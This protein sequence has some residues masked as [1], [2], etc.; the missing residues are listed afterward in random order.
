[1]GYDEHRRA[2]RVLPEGANAY[3][4]AR[5]V[6][7]DERSTIQR[8]LKFCGHTTTDLEAVHPDTIPIQMLNQPVPT[9]MDYIPPECK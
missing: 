1:M 4:L 6:V 2:F 8:M 9:I 7:F 3:I 5:S